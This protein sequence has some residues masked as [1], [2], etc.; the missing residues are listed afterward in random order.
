MQLQLEAKQH[1]AGH[2]CL[3]EAHNGAHGLAGLA[4]THRFGRRG[5][6]PA[7]PGA[8]F[9]R[10]LPLAHGIGVVVGGRAR[11]HHETGADAGTAAPV[12][13]AQGPGFGAFRLSEAIQLAPGEGMAP[14]LKQMPAEESNALPKSCSTFPFVSRRNNLPLAEALLPLAGGNDAI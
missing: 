11:L 9:G 4:R 3:A 14:V 5:D 7:E 2:Q 6:E 12:V 13:G 1:G 10:V 8:G